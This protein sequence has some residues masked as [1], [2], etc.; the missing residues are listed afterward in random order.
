MAGT[1]PSS[2]ITHSP[3]L[4]GF[5]SDEAMEAV[6]RDEIVLAG[7]MVGERAQV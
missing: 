4:Y 6:E 7:C 3:I 5:P 1:N 2:D